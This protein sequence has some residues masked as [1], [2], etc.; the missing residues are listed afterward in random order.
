MKHRPVVKEG[1]HKERNIL[2]TVRG[3]HE[4]EADLRRQGM[5]SHAKTVS[6]AL[7]LIGKYR[8]LIAGT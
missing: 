4:L 3:M 7:K 8:A 1:G 2:D 6:E 5:T